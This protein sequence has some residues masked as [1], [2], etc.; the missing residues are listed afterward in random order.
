MTPQEAARRW[1][2]SSQRVYQWL[3]GRRIPGARK[4]EGRWAIPRRARRP[5]AFRPYERVLK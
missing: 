4:K 1:R 5:R 3:Y 2:V